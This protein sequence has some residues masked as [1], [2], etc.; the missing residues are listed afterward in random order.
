M[1]IKW[2]IL[3][4]IFFTWYSVNAQVLKTVSPSVIQTIKLRTTGNEVFTIPLKKPSVFV[5]LAPDCPLSK[6]YAPLL[7]S[8]A[9]KH[10]NINF[11][12]IFPGKS[13]SF[14]EI[15]DYGKDYAVSFPLLSDPLMQLSEYTRAKVTPEVILMDQKG[16]ILYRG[17]IDNWAVSLGKKRQVVTNHYLDQA[18][19]LY[20]M[21]KP[22]TITHTDPVGCLINDI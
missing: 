16:I 5:F 8:L 22:I 7:N 17:L 14:K 21:G 3:G 2:L 6:N 15:S 12:G 13:Y 4:L 18:I 11:Y 19:S 20:E 9:K 1:K 10:P